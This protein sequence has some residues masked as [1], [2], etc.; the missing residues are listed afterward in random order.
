VLEEIYVLVA[1]LYLSL[2]IAV[3][4]LSDVVSDYEL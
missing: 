1:D 4:V 2:D 3:L